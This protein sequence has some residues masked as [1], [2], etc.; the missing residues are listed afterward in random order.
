MTN[1]QAIKLV[2]KITIT[3]I[4]LTFFAIGIIFGFLEEFY[5]SLPSLKA[6][7]PA[8]IENISYWGIPTKVYSSEGVLLA[9]F[10][11]EK[12][13]IISF[14]EIPKDMINAIIAIEDKEFYLHRGINFRGIIRATFV[15]L[16]KGWGSQGGSS[17]TQQLAKA[18]FFGPE[19]KL[20]RKIKEALL[21]IKI[22][23]QLTK[24]EILEKYFN[25]IYF[26]HGAYGLES[27]ARIYFGKSAKD[28]T[29][30]ECALLAGLPKAPNY[31][32]PI[33]NPEIA[34][35][36][37]YVVLTEMVNEKFITKQQR[38][39]AFANFWVSYKKLN[40][41][42][43]QSNFQIRTHNAPHFVEFIKKQLI[44]DYGVDTVFNGGLKVTTTIK[45]KYQQ[46]AEKS[47]SNH[48]KEINK[49]AR[50]TGSYKDQKIEGAFVSLDSH[51]GD[52]LAMVGGSEWTIDNQL[53]RAVQS[54]RQSGSTFKPFVYVTAFEQGY[55]P[56]SLVVDAPVY[57]TGAGGRPWV[58]ENYDGEYNGTVTFR[59]ALIKSLNIP[60][61][62]VCDKIGVQNVIAT[63]R[64]MG[65]KSPLA[66]YLPTAIGA[67]D[68][69]I[70]ELVNAFMPFSNKGYYFPANGLIKVLDR[71]GTELYKKNVVP[72][73][74]LKPE[75]AYQ[76]AHLL[77]GVTQPGGTAGTM[78]SK[79]D[80]PIAGKT[81]TTNNFR[82]AWFIGFTPSVVSGV[83]LGYDKG[84]L[85]L[86]GGHT[87]GQYAAPI[88][89]DFIKEAMEDE[90]IEKF[91]DVPP[92]IVLKDIC[93]VTGKLAKEN[94]PRVN[95]AF[96]LGTE[97]KEYCNS[98]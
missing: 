22:E 79:L 60:A 94:C 21:S 46:A 86:G 39:E 40:K 69:R 2:R 12:R 81:G 58:P 16:T 8:D 25:K 61:I 44:R 19:K 91:D 13:E 1:K 37:Q 89:I 34:K 43:I 63:A 59:T 65:I 90:P 30:P 70:I 3:I 41:T 82:D 4:L 66:P 51:S 97:P 87:G 80:R 57:F 67:N 56:S 92:N 7:D 32:S 64:R 95:E 68:L 52:I 85:T 78:S 9:E 50:K 36:R 5:H 48:L 84:D 14:K 38:D 72:T 11:K 71:K 42:D 45:I 75:Y 29:L 53:N 10:Y 20:T 83:W 33:R 55:T 27:A 24:E 88:F 93:S 49:T 73:R 54:L 26:G 74:V 15:N 77:L 28:L 62:K 23:L 98:H 96:I 31:Y 18:L 76:M 17:L 47:L 6:L 35:K